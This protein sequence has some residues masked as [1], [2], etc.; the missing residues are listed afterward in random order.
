MQIGLF[1]EPR[2]YDFDS[3][4]PFHPTIELARLGESLGFDFVAIGHHS[5]TPEADAAAPQNRK[6][7]DGQ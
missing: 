7:N 6:H 3:P 4:D 2:Q 5:F 1:L